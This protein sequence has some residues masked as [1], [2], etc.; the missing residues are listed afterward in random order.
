LASDSLALTAMIRSLFL[1]SIYL[2]SSLSC[3]TV[4]SE[5][6]KEVSQH[7]T[8]INLLHYEDGFISGPTSQA[9]TKSFFFSQDGKN[10]PLK[11]LQST[12][13]SFRSP[14]LYKN[15]NESAICRFP[16]RFIFLK[17][18]FNLKG[19]LKNCSKF[20]KFK[21][22]LSAKSL[23]LMFTSYFLDTPA[24][25]FGHTLFRFRKNLAGKDS[26]KY[27]LLD[28]AIN[29]SAT[30]TT[31][32]AFLYGFLGLV[33]GFKGE[34]ASMPY[35]YKVREYNDYESRDMWEYELN[36]TSEE[37]S[38]VV[39]HLWEMSNTYFSYYYLTGNC[40]YYMLKVLDVANPSWKLAKRT[41]YIVVPVDTIKVVYQTPGLVRKVRYRPSK[42]KVVEKRVDLLTQDEQKIFYD[43][44]LS[45][46]PN[47]IPKD[48]PANSKAR[49]LD[50]IIDY[51]DYKH[52]EDILMKNSGAVK[53]KREFLIE[54]ASTGIKSKNIII[55]P[56]HK[57]QPHLGHATRRVSLSAGHGRNTGNFYLASFRMS[58]HDF[59]DSSIGHNPDATIEMGNFSIRYNPKN[60]KEGD[61]SSLRLE[62]FSLINV[63]NTSPL[64]PFHGKTSWKIFLGAE[65]IK[66]KGC[67]DCT[68]PKFEIGGGIS[69]A[70]SRFR[71]LLF[72]VSGTELHKDLS[73]EGIRIGVGPHAL[74]NYQI[75]DYLKF[76]LTFDYRYHFLADQKYSH[77]HTAALRKSFGTSAAVETSFSILPQENQGQL[78]GYFYY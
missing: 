17:S 5:D 25:A 40:S 3:A 73:H 53:M 10:N 24:S 6:L 64:K 61:S 78:K 29:Y 56:P 44:Y 2:I 69:Q 59:L 45:Q 54:R 47:S 8:W 37:L 77:Q 57:E 71:Y 60:K 72:F 58:L 32:N 16:A 43:S 33:G 13:A 39:A 23:S 49:I 74:F 20:Q 11:E 21:S 36:L 12:L 18:K 31:N 9:E 4:I 62:K 30:V 35:F 26:E 68:A 66:D 42:R 55:P 75:T 38:M 7:P 52:S 76:Q 41:P 15:Y 34:F 70:W 63:V 1:F 50:T 22:R 65:T 28:Y 48:I 27:Q 19:E 51:I 67:N 46:S 14:I